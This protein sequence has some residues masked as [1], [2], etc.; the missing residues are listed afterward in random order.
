[1]KLGCTLGGEHF[2]FAGE[3]E[4]LKA[5]GINVFQVF[6]GSPEQYHHIPPTAGT[7]KAL[8]NCE[9]LIHSPY[10][11]SFFKK[12]S[13]PKMVKYLQ[14]LLRNWTLPDRELLFVTH[15]SSFKSD[16][17][18]QNNYIAYER[19]CK[20]LMRALP[21]IDER[22]KIVIENDAGHQSSITPKVDVLVKVKEL[23]EGKVGICIDTEHA[24]SDGE[25]ILN[26]PY[27]KADVIH[28]NAIPPYVAHGGHLDRHSYTSLKSSKLDMKPIISKIKEQI[29]DDVPVILERYDKDLVLDDIEYIK[30]VG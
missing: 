1:M 17:S 15:T 10:W 19:V 23:F 27:D 4:R 16:L 22:L 18:M 29:S 24:F 14:F 21:A 7:K 8:E 9:Y 11:F 25:D 6:T 3:I 5:N 26:L 28:L 12:E 13:F 2:K 30:S 20:F